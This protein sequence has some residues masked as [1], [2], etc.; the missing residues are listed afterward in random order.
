[1]REAQGRKSRPES[2]VV[3]HYKLKKLNGSRVYGHFYREGLQV[4]GKAINTYNTKKQF[5]DNFLLP[6]KF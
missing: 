6:E 4:V 5:E 2:I 3:Y 1:M